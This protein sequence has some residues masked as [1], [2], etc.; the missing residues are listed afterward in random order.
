MRIA[1]VLSLVLATTS[2]A[3]DEGKRKVEQPIR[4]SLAPASE[5]F[6]LSTTGIEWTKGLEGALNRSKP[7]LLFQ[8][9][10]NFDDVYC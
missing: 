8:L 6:D 3:Q 1:V 2:A 10:G 5:K 7:I 9:L 4:K